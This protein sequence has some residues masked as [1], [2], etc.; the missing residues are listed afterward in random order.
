M[1]HDCPA[2]R[3]VIEREGA[4]RDPPEAHGE[5]HSGHGHHGWGEVAPVTDA[6]GP[7]DLLVLASAQV[8][9]P[10]AEI[11]AIG[12]VLVA[13]SSTSGSGAGSYRLL[14]EL[15]DGTRQVLLDR[16]PDRDLGA[17]MAHRVEEVM[18]LPTS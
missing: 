5:A 3:A 12:L 18:G 7:P 16:I 10:N 11:L 14:A 13:E 15:A 2:C 4:G 1:A 9:N 17:R 6:L 8:R